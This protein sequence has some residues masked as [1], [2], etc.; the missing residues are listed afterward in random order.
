MLTMDYM[1]SND[2]RKKVPGDFLGSKVWHRKMNSTIFQLMIP[3]DE[4][5]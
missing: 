3:V 2:Q 4:N 5:N 1:I